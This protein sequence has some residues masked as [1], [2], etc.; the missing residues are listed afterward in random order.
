MH[1]ESVHL[2]VHVLQAE[3][4]V[5]A[6]GIFILAFTRCT[7]V[8][9]ILAT[10]IINYKTGEDVQENANR[11]STKEEYNARSKTKQLLQV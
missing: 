4:V 6:Q 10:K 5:F 1:D 2:C 3:R 8:F 11:G 7:H 9:P